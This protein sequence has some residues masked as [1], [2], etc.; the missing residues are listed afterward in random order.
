MTAAEWIAGLGLQPH[1]EGGWFRETYRSPETVAADALPGRF[2][3]RRSFST[4]ILFLLRRGERSAFHR[5]AADELWHFHCGGALELVVIHPDGR[6]E[7]V[8]LGCRAARGERL[9]AAVPAGAWFAA[10]PAGRS[11]Y[12]LVGCTVAP[13]FDFADFEMADPEALSA[14]FPDH[15]AIIRAMA[16]GRRHGRPA[17]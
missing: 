3:G 6:R 10:R 8:R 1:P 17:R 4:A 11:A 2:G 16:T 12:G 9:Q 14:R 15:A 7:D 5:L 13:G